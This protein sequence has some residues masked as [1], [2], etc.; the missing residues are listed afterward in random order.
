MRSEKHTKHK[1]NLNY[2]L[3]L[4]CLVGMGVFPMPLWAQDE[5][6]M[7][8]MQDELLVLPY[9][10]TNMKRSWQPIVV[11]ASLP[12][13]FRQVKE[14]RIADDSGVLSTLFSK[15]MDGVNP[16]RVVHIGDSHVRGHIFP[17]VVRSSLEREWGGNAVF[18]DTVSYKS[19]GLAQETGR[20]GIV[21]HMVGIN[22]AT[23]VRFSLPEQVQRVA[24]LQPDLIIVSLGT[25]EAHSRRYSAD[26]HER[27]LKQLLASLKE[28]CP[29]AKFMLSTPPGAYAGKLRAQ[30]VNP[31]T[32]RV[33]K[34]IV[35]VAKQE[36]MA[37]WDLYN[38]VGGREQAC[39]NWYRAGMLRADGIHFTHEGYSMQG[40]LLHEA[41]I[42]AYNDYV[43]TGL[44]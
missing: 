23:A 12:T 34:T 25:N 39:R 6:P 10:A 31:R 5:F 16:V 19:S 4:C 35:K 27:E 41:I 17:Y 2:L 1:S 37:V 15:L 24:G 30:V 20:E 14:N 40:K 11:A 7:K 21:Y 9:E 22:G 43:G 32:D 42:K 8:P 33:A 26:A 44:E 38:I 36:E 28:A 29:R 13:S 3:L 18:P